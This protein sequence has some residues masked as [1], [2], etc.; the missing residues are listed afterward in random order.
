MIRNSDKEQDLPKHGV[1]TD[2]MPQPDAR[3]HSMLH[4]HTDA[5]QDQLAN[6]RIPTPLDVRVPPSSLGQNIDARLPSSD[7]RSLNHHTED[8]GST[9]MNRQL[10]VRTSTPSGPSNHQ[11]GVTLSNPFALQDVSSRQDMVEAQ[12]QS[13]QVLFQ[14]LI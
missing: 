10:P 14:K 2:S 12:L 13:A 3:V 7:S 6:A 4:H 1:E 11:E 8:R 9:I 5:N